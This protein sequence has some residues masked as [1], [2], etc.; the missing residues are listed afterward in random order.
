MRACGCRLEI[1]SCKENEGG[2]L[3]KKLTLTGSLLLFVKK[4]LEADCGRRLNKSLRVK[5]GTKKIQIA[6]GEKRKVS[7]FDMTTLAKAKHTRQ[8]NG[9]VVEQST[10]FSQ[11]NRSIPWC[12]IWNLQS[13]K[14]YSFMEEWLRQA[15]GKNWNSV[16]ET[17]RAYPWHIKSTRCGQRVKLR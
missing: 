15:N 2:H 4:R 10:L 11:A 14:N 12:L 7:C 6:R 5:L 1:Y 17:E 16:N 9:P 8:R 3:Y 13:R